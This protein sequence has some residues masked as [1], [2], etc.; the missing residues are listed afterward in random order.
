VEL[1]RWGGRKDLGGDDG[2]DRNMLYKSIFKLKKIKR[3]ERKKG[4][5]CFIDEIKMSKKSLK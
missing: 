2:E 3:K 1:Y 5:W 4:L